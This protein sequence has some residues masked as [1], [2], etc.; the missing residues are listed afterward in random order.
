MPPTVDSSGFPDR[1]AFPWLLIFRAG[2]L[3]CGWPQLVISFLAATVFLLGLL[4]LRWTFPADSILDDPHL[5][6][7]RLVLIQKATGSITPVPRN[8]KM[9]EALDTLALPW[10]SLRLPLMQLFFGQ[11]A[12]ADNRSRLAT[13]LSLAWS[14]A[15]W[16]LFGV[17]LCRAV[18]TQIA[19]DE[20][21]SLPNC[22]RDA[23]GKWFSAVGAPAILALAILGLALGLIV[24]GWI[25]RAPLLGSP[26]LTI[27]SPL[28]FLTS[29]LAAFFTVVI[30]FG[31]PLMMA[32]LG[33]E[34]CDAFGA[35]SRSYSYLTG[36]P[37]LTVWQAALSLLYGGVLILFVAAIITAG[38]MFLSRT[39]AGP[40]GSL[41][42][43]AVVMTGAD[44]TARLFLCTFSVGLFW[45]LA[46]INYL[47]LRQ[48][49]DQK[50]IHEISSA[51]ESGRVPP[52]LPI[53]GIAATDYRPAADSSSPLT[54]DSK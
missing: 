48:A 18:A 54:T 19:T 22:L 46:T 45:S 50:P 30:L 51:D 2:G 33:V 13:V 21:E 44:Y 53:V 10:T 27:V 35:L 9:I 41:E 15:V 32:A 1:R 5:S 7:V 24:A 47:L 43:W 49:V 26:F 34:H 6:P 23:S 12:V 42:R 29:L 20:S 37:L 16:S 36:R 25:G 3:A 17:A 40:V 28:L 39:I 52:E 14:L 8:E 31:W 38:L 11:S 4:I